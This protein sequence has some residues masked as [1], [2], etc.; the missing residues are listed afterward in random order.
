[1]K[2]TG[3]GIF[4]LDGDRR[5]IFEK[6]PPIIVTPKYDISWTLTKLSKY[7]NIGK[8]LTG[9]KRLRSLV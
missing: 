8:S 6:F 3:S 9:R 4:K 7:Q 1:M 5:G 2:H